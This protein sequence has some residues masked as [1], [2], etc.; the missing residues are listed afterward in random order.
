MKEVKKSGVECPKCRSKLMYRLGRVKG[1]QR[2]RWLV[3]G[4]QLLMEAKHLCLE[5]YP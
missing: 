5:Y 1:E 4:M 3:C 2:Y